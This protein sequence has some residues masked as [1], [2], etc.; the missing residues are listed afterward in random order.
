MKNMN[1]N[2]RRS[3]PKDFVGKRVLKICDKFTEEYPCR[4]GISIKLQLQE[5]NHAEM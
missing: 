5:N 2:N 3:H 1:I 4:S